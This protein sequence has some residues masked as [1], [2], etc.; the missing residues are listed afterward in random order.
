MI[1][2]PF[3]KGK[4]LWIFLW[5]ARLGSN[6]GPRRYERPALTA[7][8][9]A[10]ETSERSER[11]SP[12]SPC[13]FQLCTKK[14]LLERFNVLMHNA[15]ELRSDYFPA[16]TPATIFANPDFLRFALLLWIKCF[17]AAVSI[18]L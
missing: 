14:T 18:I 11:V 3:I 10:P 2:K 1:F 16:P 5:W 15:A 4:I 8:L 12:C 6:Q 17:L 9:R 13:S 7:E